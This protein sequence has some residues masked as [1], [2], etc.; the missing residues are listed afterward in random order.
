MTAYNSA[1]FLTWASGASATDWT[2]YGND[3]SSAGLKVATCNLFIVS[4]AMQASLDYVDSNDP[5]SVAQAINSCNKVASAITNGWHLTFDAEINESAAENKYVL[6][7]NFSW[8]TTFPTIR[9]CKLI[10]KKEA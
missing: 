6:Y 4:P 8:N 1:N 7:I 2:N 5:H 10:H 3:I 9:S